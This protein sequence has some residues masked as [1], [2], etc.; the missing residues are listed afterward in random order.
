[1]KASMLST[2]ATNR[3]AALLSLCIS[4]TACGDDVVGGSGE[5]ST[6]DES[7]S[8]TDSPTTDPT[9]TPTTATTTGDT[10]G[11]TTGDTDTDATS[12]TDTDPTT[13]PGTDSDSDTDPSGSSTTGGG[14]VCGD[15]AIED[16][17]VC[18]GADL[19][20]ETC[21]GLGFVGG[22]E[23]ACADDCSDYDTSMCV[24]QLCANDVVEGD[25]VCD[26]ADLADTT[27]VDLGFDGGTLGCAKDCSAFDTS[28]CATALT[29][30]STPAAAIGAGDVA[31]TTD[32]ITL[33]AGAFVA[34]V[35]IS[36]DATHAAVG[37]LDLTITHNDTTTS[38]RLQSGLCG[39]DMD[40]NGEYDAGAAAAPA[41]GGPPA[42]DGAVLPEGSL[43]AFTGIPDPAGVWQLDI[44]DNDTDASEGTLNEW[45]VNYLVT[46]GNPEACGNDVVTFTEVCDGMNIPSTCAA[47]L[48]D[49]GGYGTVSCEADCGA[50]DSTQCCTADV[51]D[52]G[53]YVANFSDGA[54]GPCADT[55]IIDI[56]ATGTALTFPAGADCDFSDAPV[57]LPAA[58]SLHGDP[59]VDWYVN[60]CPYIAIS[61]VQDEDF[62]NDCPMNENRA[63][64]IAAF[65]DD[66]NLDEG[67]M[68][69]HQHFDMGECPRPSDIEGDVECDVFFWDGINAWL[70][71]DVFDVN[72]VLYP[73]T[74]EAVS[75]FDAANAGLG[76]AT[77]GIS[78]AAGDTAFTAACN[79]GDFTTTADGTV[80]MLP[81]NSVCPAP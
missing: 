81:S 1:M 36:V 8:T 75:V 28:L 49:L 17:E 24:A 26:G 25:E 22:G 14:A 66:L 33:P 65:H 69:Y 76:S 3:L 55:D 11:P 78:N 77:I 18:D 34:D 43:D 64:T 52:D 59:Q 61:N 40:I 57:T 56:S 42:V 47:E 51:G 21:E 35:N 48:G 39:A 71:T 74:G 12:V 80:C 15:D 31:L 79:D 32:T 27:C 37:D 53:A 23:L 68:V 70:S 41:C 2:T 9:V 45:C 63:G 72:L 60:S 73:T 10:E 13:G 29:M 19:A 54:A 38:A 44:T 62:T 5:S 30:C 7:D 6:G 50:V 46:E 58:F 20:D 4:A 16:K 67:G